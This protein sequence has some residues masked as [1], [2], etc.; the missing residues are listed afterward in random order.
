MSSHALVA[1]GK[2][3]RS[4]PTARPFSRG[5]SQARA[6]KATVGALGGEPRVSLLPAEVN[7]FHKARTARRRLGLGVVA[8]LILTTIGIAGA[9]YLNMQAQAALEASR[10]TSQSLLAQQAEF[11]DLRQAQNGIEL[12]EAGQLV[13]ASTEIEWPDYLNKLQA[14]LPEG[15][16]IDT[17]TIDSASPFVDYVQSTVPLASTRVATVT[18][19]AISPT[20]PS[21]PSWLDGLATLTGFADAVPNSVS[22]KED[23]TY[24]VN[25][26]MHINSAAFSQRFAREEGK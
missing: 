12:T 11:S 7:D 22:L 19:T 18:F 1:A 23:G 10:L 4:T 16:M 24:L 21:I 9:G 17:V 5:G 26:T 2:A 25:I 3:E 13:G 14:T 20:I 8:V 15:V 6:A